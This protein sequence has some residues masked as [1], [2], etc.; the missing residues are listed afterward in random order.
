ME[1]PAL[2]LL[3]MRY[4]FRD[5]SNLYVSDVLQPTHRVCQHVT[6]DMAR[7]EAGGERRSDSRRDTVGVFESDYPKLVRPFTVSHASEHVSKPWFHRNGATVIVNCCDGSIPC[8]S[9]ISGTLCQCLFTFVID[10]DIMVLLRPR[11]QE[12]PHGSV[13]AVRLQQKLRCFGTE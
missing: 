2:Q 11:A 6:R 9:S 12:I 10:D 7:V 5:N 13:R 4:M 8:Q 1:P 3:R